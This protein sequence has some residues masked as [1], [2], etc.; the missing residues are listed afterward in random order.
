MALGKVRATFQTA[1]TVWNN[2]IRCKSGTIII[3]REGNA[4]YVQWEEIELPNKIKKA[5][6]P[7]E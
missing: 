3:T 6:T 7:L 4:R 1:V 2:I 5:K